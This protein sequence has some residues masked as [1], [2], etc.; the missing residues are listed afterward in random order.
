MSV[1]QTCACELCMDPQ[2][3][4]MTDG[5]YDHHFVS[6]YLSKYPQCIKRAPPEP[7][8]CIN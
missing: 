1:T 8:S 5:D 6:T 2:V 4:A 3:Y 7:P